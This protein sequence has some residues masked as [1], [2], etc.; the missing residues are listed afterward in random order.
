MARYGL[1][2][3]LIF[4]VSAQGG[5]AERAEESNEVFQSERML[6]IRISMTAD[7][8]QMMQPVQASRLAV[9]MAVRQHPT[10]QEALALAR[11]PRS[12]SLTEKTPMD[13]ERRPPGLVGNEYAYVRALATIDDESYADVGV[14]FKGQ[15]SYTLAGASPRRPLKIDFNRFVRG[16]HFH[17][18]KSL[19]L[20]TNALDPSQLRES[21]GYGFF[22]EAGVCAPRTC[23]ALVYLTVEGVYKNELLGLYTVVEEVN[24]DFLYRHFGTTKGLLIRPERTR[25]LAY[26]G[27][28]WEDYS[29]YNIQ[30]EPTAFTAGRFMDFTRS[31]HVSSDEYFCSEIASALDADRFLRF[32]AA[33]VLMVNLDGVLVNGHNFYV[34]VHPKTGRLTFIPW[35]LHLGFGWQGRSLEDWVS[36]TIERPYRSGNRLVERVL[37]VGWMRETYE[38]YLREF[39]T[40]CFS[41]ERMHGRIER[42][43]Q[44]VRKAEEIARGEGRSLPVS[45]PASVSQPRADLKPF[46]T[47]R[48]QHVLDQLA[49]RVT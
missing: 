43:E 12:D 1:I 26:F 3:V 9:A 6:T 36:L 10:T 28:R 2:F 25:N 40:T 21:L 7:R 42:L 44:V 15:W 38:H 19:S 11:L 14:R 48:V 16:G 29:R 8:W 35:D 17:G 24:E 46:V 34:H 4:S 20:N 32:L 37:S 23:F 33:N 22:R 45:M 49:G 13:G 39:A 18:I 5:R 27:N 47:G 31:I 41:P 30:T